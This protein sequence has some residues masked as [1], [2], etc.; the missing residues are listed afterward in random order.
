VRQEPGESY[1]EIVE[2]VARVLTEHNPWHSQP[3]ELLVT[4]EEDRPPNRALGFWR[5]HGSELDMRPE[6]VEAHRVIDGWIRRVAANPVNNPDQFLTMLNDPKRARFRSAALL[7]TTREQVVGVLD[8]VLQLPDDDGYRFVA[9]LVAVA[10]AA[11]CCVMVRDETERHEPCLIFY[12]DSVE[13]AL[14]RSALT[15]LP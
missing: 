7:P 13:V 15:S 2:Q 5:R 4:S 11:E 8:A 6:A 1:P 12:G 10:A 3:W 9:G 14:I